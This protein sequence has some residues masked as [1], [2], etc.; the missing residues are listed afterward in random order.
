M[1]DKLELIAE[2]ISGQGAGRIGMILG[3]LIGI[4]VLV[5]GFWKTVFVLLCGGIGLYLGT[6]VESGEDLVE[7]TLSA[8]HRRVPERFR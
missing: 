6:R 4:A 3:V 7:R 8:V 5:F 2:R 1:W